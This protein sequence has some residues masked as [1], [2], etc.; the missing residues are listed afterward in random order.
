M[1]SDPIGLV[2]GTNTYAYV[3]GNPLKL[4]DRFG[5]FTSPHHWFMTQNAFFGSGL[6]QEFIQDVMM[7][8]VMADFA[9]G[10]QS[11]LMAHTHAMAKPGETQAEAHDNYYDYVMSE[12]EKCDS[13]GL[14]NALHAVQDSASESHAFQTYY[15]NV[16]PSHFWQ[17]HTPSILRINEA[18]NKS[19]YLIKL[20]E[21]KCSCGGS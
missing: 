3:S 21:E 14:G 12:I 7:A 11:I 17:D 5:L 15:G 8:S 9:E 2:A 18:V 19:Q 4:I 10:S 6:S 16:S 1:T 13:T 20:Y